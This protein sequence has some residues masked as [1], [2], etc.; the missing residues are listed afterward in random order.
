MAAGWTDTGRVFTEGDGSWLRPLNVT[1]TFNSMV[2]ATQ[3]PPVRLHDLCHGAA[4]LTHASGGDMHYIKSTLGHSSHH[5]TSDVYA[6]LLPQVDKEIAEKAIG[7]V[8][9]GVRRTLG[10][11]PVTQTQEYETPGQA[12]RTAPDPV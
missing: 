4:R 8:P 10:H 7:L 11:A 2:R 9:I 5:F 6:D 12:V 1:Q 3:L